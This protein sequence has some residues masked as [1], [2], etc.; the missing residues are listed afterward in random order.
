MIEVCSRRSHWH[1][2][3]TGGWAGF[4]SQGE[5]SEGPG[6]SGRMAFWGVAVSKVQDTQ[7]LQLNDGDVIPLVRTLRPRVV[8]KV[9]DSLA[10]L[11]DSETP[12]IRIRPGLRR[13]N[14]E[15]LRSNLKFGGH[16]LRAHRKDLLSV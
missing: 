5:R 14:P 15:S 16:Q 6:A 2:V 12:V 4:C 11:L 1:R 10:N 7:R 8:A 13:R 9:K 3:E